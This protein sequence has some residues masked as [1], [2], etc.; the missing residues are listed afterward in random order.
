MDDATQSQEP[1]FALLADPATY[2]GHAHLAQAHIAQAHGHHAV[3][4]ID[5]HAASLF[6]AGERA[7]KVKRAVRFPF[8]DYS[9]LEK[10][11]AACETELAINRRTAPDIYRRVV[12]I[13]READGRLALDGH[14]EPVE[15]TLEMR[16]F[17]EN[18]TLDHLAAAGKI[19]AALADA[20]GRTVAASHADAEP[21]DAELWIAALGSYIDE[22]AEAFAGRPELFPADQ[23]QAF[24]EAGRAAF[25]RI[26]PLLD[27]RGR[28][29]FIRR[30]HGDLHL[31]NI[32]LIDDRPVL[33]DAIE[34][35]EVI[36]S[37]DV[38]YDLAFLLMDLVER[39]LT[40]AA[41]IVFNR[42]LAEARH[43]ENLDAL[44]AL[45]FFLAMRAAI[46]AK[47]TVARLA[48]AKPD[49]QAAI[50]HSARTYF[51]F[52]RRFIAPAKPVLVALGGLSGTGK[53]VLARALAP[54]L[55]PAPGAVVIR[56]DVERKALFGKGELEA[57]PQ[58]AYEPEVTGRVYDAIIEKARRAV[59]AGHS[60][61]VDAVFARPGERAQAERAALDISARFVGLF[62]EADVATRAQ[63]A[64][65]RERD[66][67]DA[68]AE[69]ARAQERYDLGALTWRR[70]DASGTPDETLQRAKA[71]LA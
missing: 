50:E 54:A 65:A 1:V 26:R 15:W 21:A 51:D 41:N 6:L 36:A 69:V 12:A 32:V 13:T 2:G 46:R 63:R 42:Y 33:F 60:A 7:L 53:S 48:H 31:G 23:N 4:R 39:D 62:L 55:A 28:R 22:H 47:V 44:M 71:I 40:P 17:D 38:L 27:A 14:G 43:N 49:E 70:I 45:P 67:S 68:D 18:L 66:A 52:A 34:F 8:L 30:I 9:T 24:A 25:A 58:D 3:K 57:L 29:G 19:D 16:R 35:S 5:T 59:A 61:I 11:K 20:L 37:G 56:S 64:G 10:R